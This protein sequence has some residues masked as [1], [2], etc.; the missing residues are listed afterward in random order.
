MKRAQAIA[1][2]VVLVGAGIAGLLWVSHELAKARA[3]RSWPTVEGKISTS[4]VEERRRTGG[5]DSPSYLVYIV[6]IRYSYE[7]DGKTYSSDRIHF[8]RGRRQYR[9]KDTAEGL[10]DRYSLGK[11]V[12]VYHH[13]DEPEIAVLEAGV[14]SSGQVQGARWTSI[15]GLAF[16]AIVLLFT[17]R[18][19]SRTRNP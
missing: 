13:P 8:F 10:V 18:G 19:G 6:H 16:G 2:G 12:T 11:Q 5:R 7:V 14:S 17:L 4:Y 15:A 1:L 3:S 9:V